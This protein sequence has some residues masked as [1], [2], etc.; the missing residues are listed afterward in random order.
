[1]YGRKLLIIDNIR[2][3]LKF[4][5]ELVDIVWICVK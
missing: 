2:N 5:I 3:Y 1:M 4:Y